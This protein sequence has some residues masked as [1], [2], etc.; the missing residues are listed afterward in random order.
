[1]ETDSHSAFFFRHDFIIFYLILCM[2]C[3]ADLPTLRS[4][5]L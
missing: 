3:F 2:F 1:M 4:R 5:T